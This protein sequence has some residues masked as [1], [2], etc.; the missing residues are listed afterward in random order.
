MKSSLWIVAA[1]VSAHLLVPQ[2]ASAQGKPGTKAGDQATKAG[3]AST[4]A[5]D[6]KAGA[7][8]GDAKA[9]PKADPKGEPS[10]KDKAMVFVKSGDKAASAGEWEDAYADYSIAWTMYRGWETA[11][12]V[13]KAA[14]KTGHHAEA[15]ERLSYFLREAPAK[16]VTPKQR[17]EIEAM[18]AES[19][20]KTGLLAIVAPP[21][22]EVFVDRNAVGKT[23]LAEPLRVDPGKHE[24]E[25]RRGATGET[26]STEVVAGGTVEVKFEPPKSG[27][28][29]VII[30]QDPYRWRTPAL[31]TGAALSV[32]GLAL[33]GVS[34]GLSFER[35]GA[36]D[37][38]AKDPF[39]RDAF[40][41]ASEDEALFKNMMVWSFIGAGVALG[42]TAAVFFVT[43]TPAQPKVQGSLGFGPGGPSM[44]I[45]G[46]F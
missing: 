21:D 34:L 17:A 15:F 28:A 26:K 24:I 27:P 19:K 44:S 42:G 43:R 45:R 12:G 13:G 46:E 23:P 29:K 35:A 33:G 3:A 8:A 25:I 22:G 36:R 11:G 37:A 6:A 18:I 5:G 10:P 9:D 30:Q 16:N 41:N 2:T 7:K 40:N 38:A 39:G 31:I 4:K 1:C 14:N 20:G 32:A